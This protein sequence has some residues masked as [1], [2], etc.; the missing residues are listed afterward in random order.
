MD[1]QTTDN[2]TQNETGLVQ[3]P[4]AT[5]L[6]PLENQ[7]DEFLLYRKIAGWGKFSGIMFIISGS[8]SALGGVIAL[9]VGAIPGVLEIIIGVFL[10]KSAIAAGNIEMDA[11]S[12]KEMLHYYAKYVQ[13]TGILMIIG[14]VLVALVIIF[15]IVAGAAFIQ[16]S[17]HITF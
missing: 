6:P 3:T 2:T 1:D 14:L 4:D 11:A 16:Q 9:I 5:G 17:N 15:C 10:L 13:W 7:E 12:H 8:L